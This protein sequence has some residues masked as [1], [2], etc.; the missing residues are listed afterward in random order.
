MP[1]HV[2]AFRVAFRLRRDAGR[3]RGADPGLVPVRR[4]ARAGRGAGRR[5]AAGRDRPDARAAGAEPRRRARATSC[6]RSTSS[7]TWPPTPSCWPGS[8]ASP[9]CCGACA[10]AAAGWASSRPRCARRSSWGST[11]WGWTRS[12]FEVIVDDGGHR[13]C[14]SPIRLRCCSRCERLSVEPGRG[15]LR[16]RL[17]LRPARRARRRRHRRRGAVGRILARDE[18]LAERARPGVRVAGARWRRERR[19]AGGRA[20]R[21][22]STRPT[23]ATTCST[24]R[25]STTPSTTP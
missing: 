23:T 12:A 19:G 15:D 20:A 3:L 6:S 4:A 1:S 13:R 8:T 25:R 17:A 5:R 14:T 9:R 21:A 7:T 18:L 11:A 2:R 22:A 24:S 10:R 16:R